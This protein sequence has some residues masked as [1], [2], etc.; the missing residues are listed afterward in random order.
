MELPVEL[1]YIPYEEFEERFSRLN[2]IAR[3]TYPTIW[4]NIL[5]V[6]IFGALIV[7]AAVGMARNQA[8]LAVMGQVAC[9]VIP[10]L[11][12][13]WIRVRKEGKARA[14]KQFKRR[15]IKLLREWTEQD[16]T[17]FAIQWKLRLRVWNDVRRRRAA[18]IAAAAAGSDHIQEQEQDQEVDDMQEQLPAQQQSVPIH[19]ES[20]DGNNNDTDT[21]TTTTIQRPPR[22]ADVYAALRLPTPPNYITSDTDDTPTL[23]T[24]SL[25]TTTTPSP[26]RMRA[27]P[28]QQGPQ[29]QQ[30]EAN[31]TQSTSDSPHTLL[32]TSR[33]SWIEQ[34]RDLSS[35][36][37]FTETRVWMIE[38]SR[39]DG[40]MDE[41]ALAV[42]SPVYCGYRLPGYE[43]VLLSQQLQQQDQAQ[44]ARGGA[45]GDAVAIASG[46][47]LSPSTAAVNSV[48]QQQQSR[49]GGPPPAYFSDSED[50]DE[51]DDDEE[52]RVQSGTITPVAGGSSGGNGGIIGPIES[53]TGGMTT[54]GTLQH[55]R[56]IEMTTVTLSSGPT[57]PSVAPNAR[58]GGHLGRIGN[59]HRQQ[60]GSTMSG[61]TMT[62]SSTC[63]AATSRT[64][65]ALTLA[66]D[67]GDEDVISSTN[68]GEGTK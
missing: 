64:T 9:F 6:F 27:P 44:H 16:T 41:Y 58:I 1:E 40:V 46:V 52:E 24:P 8:G 42:P 31:S 43:D 13:L 59:H 47:R 2:Q 26:H 5:M 18:A 48:P 23:S 7:T 53:S 25:T 38:I 14:R 61:S 39:R 63:S 22:V 32:E 3:P 10:V 68:K 12:I 4:P 56:P 15:S 37:L 19:I 45:G 36:L 29:Q 60:Q 17:A 28:S 33:R 11:A 20:V 54:S 50:E 66:D 21:Q 65:L 57:T 62:M 55:Q 67:V 51:D 49:Y 30:Q 35:R 34:L